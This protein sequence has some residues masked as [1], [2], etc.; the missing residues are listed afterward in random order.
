METFYPGL[1]DMLKKAGL[2]VQAQERYPIRTA[3]DQRTEQPI[4][5]DAKTSGGIKAFSTNSSSVLKWCLNRS[6][7]AT[8]T[9]A[10]DDLAGLR[11]NDTCYKPVTPSQILKSESLVGKLQT[12]LENEYLKPFYTALEKIQS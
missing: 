8:N 3:V 2:P 4:N 11:K 1:K 12:V 9:K 5:R 7:Q 6:E 10:L